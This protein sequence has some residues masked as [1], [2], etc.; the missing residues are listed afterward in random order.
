MSYAVRSAHGRVRQVLANTLK[1]DFRLPECVQ[2]Y[3]CALTSEHA[4]SK[5]SEC[6]AERVARYNDFVVGVLCLGTLDSGEDVLLCFEP[7]A[8]ETLTGNAVGADGGGDCGEREVGDPVADAAGAAEGKHD[9][10]VGGVGG[11][12]AGYIGGDAVFEFGQRVGVGGFDERAVAL[13][14]G[15]FC[16]GGVVVGEA[17]GG[18]RILAVE[19]D[20]G[21]DIC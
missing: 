16:V 13:G 6:A 10:L 21:E 8:P 1:T 17:V 12:E 3:V 19:L 20:L 7:T 18:C 9:D 2:I 15:D 11:D 4:G 5:R 14:A